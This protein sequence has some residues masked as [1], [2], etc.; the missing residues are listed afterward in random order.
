MTR[1]RVRNAAD[2]E[3]VERAEVLD[4]RDVERYHDALHNVLNTKDGR[5]VIRV[6]LN[7]CGIGIGELPRNPFGESATFTAYQCGELH[8]G[9]SL[10]ADARKASPELSHLME[11]EGIELEQNNG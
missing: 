3:Q 2:P 1:Q 11:T 6:L 9:Q 5:V 10:Q 8:I 4:K 7:A